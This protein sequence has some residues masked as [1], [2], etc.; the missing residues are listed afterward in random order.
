[1]I[2]TAVVGASNA[3]RER[4]WDPKSM[5]GWADP[6]VDQATKAVYTK[7]FTVFGAITLAIVGLYLIWRSRQSDMSNALTT[8]GWALLVMV[9]VT[10][11]AAW[12]VKSANMADGTLVSALGV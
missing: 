4:A 7:V 2:A 6:L 11:L 8:T 12:P 1:M 9:A 3:V 5:W 10:A